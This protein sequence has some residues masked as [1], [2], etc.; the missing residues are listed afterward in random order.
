MLSFVVVSPFFSLFQLV[1]DVLS[2]FQTGELSHES[3][4]QD[5]MPEIEDEWLYDEVGKR[6]NQMVP[7]PVSSYDYF[8][9]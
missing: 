3:N 4:H 8:D 5:C 1:F 6:L 9:R 7:V 2:G